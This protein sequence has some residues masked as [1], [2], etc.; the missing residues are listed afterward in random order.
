MQKP[1]PAIAPDT[2]APEAIR[3]R[4][5][6]GALDSLRA[7]LSI[8]QA[9]IALGLAAPRLAAP[10]LAAPRLAAPRLPAVPEMA[11]AHGHRTWLVAPSGPEA[12]AAGPAAVPARGENAGAGCSLGSSA[13]RLLALLDQ[14][15][16]GAETPPALLGVTPQRIYQL[17]VTLSAHGLIRSADP[18]FPVFVLARN[19]DP[20]I[21]LRPDQQRCCRRFPPAQATTLA[22][23]AV[24]THMPR[25]KTSAVAEALCQLGLIEKAEAAPQGDLYRLTAL[26]SAHWQR[27]A[28]APRAGRPQSAAAVPVGPGAR[29]AV[30]LASHGPARTWHIWA[31]AGDFPRPRSTR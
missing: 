27:S 8:Q 26:G 4:Y 2:A 13:T 25:G 29:R 30:A 20:A 24:V 5:R 1:P 12:D 17:V 28:T 6:R 18:R 22:K 3:S 31:A 19:D 16:H 11:A 9:Q 10:K 15:R 23:I 14:P 21:L 7:H